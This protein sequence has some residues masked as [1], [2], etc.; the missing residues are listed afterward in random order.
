MLRVLALTISLSY[1]IIG[2]TPSAPTTKNQPQTG[3]EE[4][5]QETSTDKTANRL[6]SRLRDTEFEQWKDPFR[7]RILAPNISSYRQ[8]PSAALGTVF[9]RVLKDTSSSCMS[10]D[11]NAYDY[12]RLLDHRTD[13]CKE[14]IYPPSSLITKVVSG[15]STTDLKFIFGELAGKSEYAF[16]LFVTE[17]VTAVLEQPSQCVNLSELTK[18]Q[19][20]SGTCQINYITGVVVTQI[21]HKSYI[22]SET[23]GGFNYSAIKLNGN[24]YTSNK[25]ISNNYVITVDMVDVTN[26][27]AIRDIYSDSKSINEYHDTSPTLQ[28]YIQ[29]IHGKTGDEERL[30]SLFNHD[31][32]KQR[33]DSSRVDP[34]SLSGQLLRAQAKSD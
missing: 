32:F 12:K 13:A 29:S 10:E 28:T 30:D 11:T 33:L 21:T 25:N 34:L 17:P 22:Q 9:V 26:E 5:A 20:P 31:I 14:S 24:L 18:T 4:L 23:S 8:N 27:F 7:G 2:C 16:E 6:L 15:S 1:L 3:S 19:V